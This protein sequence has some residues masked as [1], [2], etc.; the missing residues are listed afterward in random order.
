MSVK[1]SLYELSSEFRALKDTLLALEDGDDDARAEAMALLESVDATMDIKVESIIMLIKE[2]LA[3]AAACKQQI[4]YFAANRKSHEAAAAGLKRYLA[5]SFELAGVK[6]AGTDLHHASLRMGRHSVEIKE[7]E[8]VPEDFIKV[9]KSF[10]KQLLGDALRAHL[11]AKHGKDLPDV[12]VDE[13]IPGVA[14]VRGAP[15]VTVK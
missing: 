3:G 5:S 1:V 14:Y 8:K 13:E 11:K 12:F 15:S 10:N 2:F 9:E 7:P 4:E 6:K